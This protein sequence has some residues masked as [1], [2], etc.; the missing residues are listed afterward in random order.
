MCLFAFKKSL[1]KRYCCCLVSLLLLLPF[2]LAAQLWNGNLGAPIL[3]MDFGMGNSKPLPA[4]M[5]QYSYTGGCPS[6]ASY[7]I[8]HFLFG[9]A[10]GSWIMLVGDHTGNHDGNYMLVNG[11]LG[12]GTVYMDTL[13]GL[14][15]NTTYQFSAWIAN[16]L[17]SF[18]CNRS[19][20]LTNL[21]LS[22][23]TVT[24]TVL[25]SYTTGEIPVSDS[26]LWKEYGVYYTTP[27]TTNALV[28]R[29]S[30]ISGGAC[31][32]V[33]IMDDITL[34][35]AGPAIAANING[36][37]ILSLDL[38]KGYTSLYTLQGTYS[39]GFADPFLQWQQSADSGST[40]LD[41]P[42]ANTA[43]YVLPHRDDSVIQYHLT[44][45]ERVNRGNPKCSINSNDIYTNVHKLP[46]SNLQDTALG[47]LGKQLVLTPS[48]DFGNFLWTSPLGVI[49][50]EPSLTIP[51][52]KNADA[53][54]YTL[55]LTGGFGCQE[56]D[57]VRVNAFPGATI[58]TAPLY[59]ICEGATLHLSATG[60]GN[61]NWSPAAGLS[62]TH[63][64]D[65]VVT[66]ADSVQYK[67]VLTNS[68]GCKDSALVNINVYKRL[69]I[70]AGTDKAILLGDTVLLD[71][72]VYGTAINYSWSSSVGLV[73]HPFEVQ[74]AVS[75]AVDTR[76]TLKAVSSVGCG[77]ANA[78]VTV[79]VF[80]DLFL[81]TAFTPNGDGLNDVYHLVV[82][83]SYQLLSFIIYNRYGG[84]VFSTTST[85]IA[86]DGTIA[87]QPQDAGQY[88]YYL[89]I[90]HPS[91]K[92][93]TRK[94]TILLLK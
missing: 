83:G 8:E 5:S 26:K 37:N 38:C 31:G 92:K 64:A 16:C 6:S 12:P 71:G 20:V 33:F 43:A 89:Q 85:N 91:G 17:Q 73:D 45:A 25:A 32:S 59:N 84:K 81:P 9:C 90:K 29:I 80:K 15:G 76:Y 7:S 94:G 28:V 51:Q 61:Y 50:R 67:V 22:I 79:K 10:G 57:S 4:Y 3:N 47:C 63:I 18:A 86:W 13:T 48:L 93:I 66:P 68:F 35:A 72:S 19:P 14:C 34:K 42:G 60:N 88:V 65:P 70:S 23:E 77:S 56:L 54:L 1:T 58:A 41:I 46:P 87:G 27:A 30:N 11:A 69:V 74:P 39:P 36:E 75:P 52:L 40:W 21:T 24:G 2:T 49:T 78:S 55:L 44:I 53:G 62:D 82:P